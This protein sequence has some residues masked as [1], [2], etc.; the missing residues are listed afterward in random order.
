M[1]NEVEQ[2]LTEGLR[3]YAIAE[4]S[5]GLAQ[6]VLER[7]RAERDRR[8]SARWEWWGGA[9][10]AAVA[11]AALIAL[12]WIRSAPQTLRVQLAAPRPPRMAA[13][14]QAPRLS[15]RHVITLPKRR[16]F[17]TPTPLTAEERA[18]LAFAAHS[19]DEARD[20]GRRIDQ[21]V[22]IEEI[23]IAPLDNG[24]SK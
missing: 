6:R 5:A 15:A 21:P 19:P 4:P 22:R 8:R 16:R 13:V 12:L 1:E 9:L 17:P 3:Q 24:D 7:V 10:A 14:A 18:L 11:S 23:Q 2:A 20:F